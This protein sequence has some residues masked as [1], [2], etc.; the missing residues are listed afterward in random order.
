MK[1]ISSY[2]KD[3]QELQVVETYLFDELKKANGDKNA[4]ESRKK[5]IAETIK[6][7]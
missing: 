7:S 4:P 3:L 1:N 6:E 2:K 5:E